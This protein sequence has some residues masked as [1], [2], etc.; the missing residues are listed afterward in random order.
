MK[1][2]ATREA[3]LALGEKHYFTGVSC[4]NGHICARFVSDY[5]CVECNKARVKRRYKDDKK[6]AAIVKNRVSDWQKDNKQKVNTKNSLWRKDNPAIV[7]AAT[8]RRFSSKRNRTPKWIGAEE[9]WL[10]K[11]VY[12]LAAIRTKLHG[13][14]WHVDHITPLQGVLVSGLH[15][16]ENLQVI[17]GAYNMAKSNSFLV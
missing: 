11:E 7:N 1:K 6:H 10:I 4:R 9:K 8:A 13:F 15:V 14:S 2:C 3:A 5:K 12:D 17:P 16:P